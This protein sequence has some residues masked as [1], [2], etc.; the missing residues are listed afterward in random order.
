MTIAP[1]SVI[2]GASA[3]GTV[4]LAAAPV[5]DVTVTLGSSLPSAAAVPAATRRGG[6][7]RVVGAV[8]AADVGLYVR[9]MG[10]RGVAGAVTPRGRLGEVALSFVVR[11]WG[12]AECAA[13]PVQSPGGAEAVRVA[14]DQWLDHRSVSP[15]ASSSSSS[16]SLF[17]FALA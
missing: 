17:L 9:A 7:P 8:A 15:L 14:H 12:G 2:G 16:Y 4:K 6:P 10:G 1:T 5:G 3:V 13:A 11:S